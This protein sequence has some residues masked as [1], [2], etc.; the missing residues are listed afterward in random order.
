MLKKLIA[1]MK[2]MSVDPPGFDPS[3]LNDPVA[4]KTRWTPAKGGGASFRTHNLVK[5]GAD[6]LEFRAALGAKLFYLLFLLV[7]L[8]VMIGFLTAR[9][10]TGDFA[11][12]MDLLIPLLIGVVFTCIGGA[13]LYFG[14]A[15]IVFDRR[16][17][18]FWK[19]RTAP[20]ETMNKQA[21]KNCVELDR[22]HALQ[23]MS[24]YCRSDKSSYYSYELNIVLPDGGRVN[25]VDHGNPG[26]LR[27]DAATLAEFLE[28]PVWD[29]I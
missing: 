3:T 19:G 25:V 5:V 13:L 11:F 28:K 22:I 7:G 24:E 9:F 8:G 4:L 21:L 20:H 2:S 1:K 15:P 14:T 16:R 18:F 29:G 23:L 17:G 26:K 10:S 12:S 27:E 6:R